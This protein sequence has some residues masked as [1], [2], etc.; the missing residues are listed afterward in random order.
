M[1]YLGN[2]ESITSEIHNLLAEKK[3]LIPELVFFDAFFC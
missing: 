2:K 3:L 1:R